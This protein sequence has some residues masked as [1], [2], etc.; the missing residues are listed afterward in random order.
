MLDKI[1]SCHDFAPPR[2][3]QLVATLLVVFYCPFLRYL[4]ICHE[5]VFGW[6]SIIEQI[7]VTQIR[8]YLT[9]WTNGKKWIRMF[10]TKYFV[11]HA[12]NKVS[13]LTNKNWYN[14]MKRKQKLTLRSSCSGKGAIIVCGF[15]KLVYL[16]K[17]PKKIRIAI[18]IASEWQNR[19]IK[20]GNFGQPG[21]FIRIMRCSFWKT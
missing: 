18:A 2:K 6:V 16:L 8:K 9:F 3:Y 17:Y 1:K 20:F 5:D 12:C 7:Q 13:D 11:R 15:H 4:Y 19:V 21:K 10:L 14:A